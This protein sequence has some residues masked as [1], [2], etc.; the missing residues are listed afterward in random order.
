M[1]TVEEYRKLAEDCRA[2]AAKLRDDDKR[3]L[4]LMAAAWDKVATER[5]AQLGNSAEPA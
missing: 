5:E 4:E 2:L 1:K 3:A